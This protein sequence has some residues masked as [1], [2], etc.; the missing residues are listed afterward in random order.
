MTLIIIAHAVKQILNF[1]TLLHPS[2]SS[3]SPSTSFS[4]SSSFSFPRL[5]PLSSPPPPWQQV[6]TTPTV[7]VHKFLHPDLHV[8]A[9]KAS[10]SSP[11][12]MPATT[13][14]YQRGSHH[15]VQEMPLQEFTLILLPI[16]SHTTFNN[17]QRAC[18]RP[19]CS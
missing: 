2:L 19:Q 12:L 16:R 10:N 5:S 3:F 7:K 17:N 15:L 9:A 14:S 13:A 4:P 18:M 1:Q 6:R 11:W 8:S